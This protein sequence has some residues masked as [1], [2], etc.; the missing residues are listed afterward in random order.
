MRKGIENGNKVFGYRIARRDVNEELY[1][2]LP[3]WLMEMA[4]LLQE[5]NVQVS[6]G[7]TITDAPAILKIELERLL[8]RLKEEPDKLRS[9]T[10]F[11]KD[12]DIPEAQS[13]MKMLHA[14]AESGTGNVKIQIHNLIVRVQEMQNIADEIRSK[15]ILFQMKM[16][17]S[18]PVFAVT[19]KL[20]LDLSIGM[21][22]MLKLLGDI[23]GA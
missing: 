6:I 8:H 9:Y 18:Y 22:Y 20:M 13:A 11:C 5:N 17:F 23:G 3:Q 14:I 4:L 21:L 7:K 15:R 2:V 19:S 10:D 1:L 16:I 12:F